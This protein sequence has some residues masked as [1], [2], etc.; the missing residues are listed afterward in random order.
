M[1]PVLR[2]TEY[3]DLSKALRD[4]TLRSI[5]WRCL[6]PIQEA[7]GLNTGPETAFYETLSE[8]VC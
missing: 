3:A 2:V 7:A 6:L 4:R 5:A 1:K 8:V